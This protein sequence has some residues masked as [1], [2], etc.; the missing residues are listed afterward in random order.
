MLGNVRFGSV[1]FGR[2]YVWFGSV[3]QKVSSVDPYLGES[4]IDFAQYMRYNVNLHDIASSRMCVLI[5]PK[6]RE[7]KL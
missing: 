6:F 7:Q 5:C 4:H 2:K 3:R 1:R